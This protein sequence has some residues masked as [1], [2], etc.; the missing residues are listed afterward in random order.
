M[1]TFV[2]ETTDKHNPQTMM[3]S[4]TISTRSTWVLAAAAAVGVVAAADVVVVVVVVAH[5]SHQQLCSLFC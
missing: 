3:A 1:R 4:I 2:L 5:S